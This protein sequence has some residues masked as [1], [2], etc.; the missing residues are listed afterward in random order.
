M[1]WLLVAAR[2]AHFAA[3]LSLLG[4]LVFVLRIARPA[5]A[6]ARGRVPPSLLAP[7]RT[8]AAV[9]W[10]VALLGAI[11]WIALVARD[12]SGQSLWHSVAGDS[13]RLVLLKTQFGHVS[14]L[15]FLLMLAVLPFVAALGR[16]RSSDGVGTMLAAMLVAATAWLGHAGA[17]TG[18]AGAIH[19][20]ADALHLVAAG[21]WVGALLPL[22]LMLSPARRDAISDGAMVARAAATA[23]SD[24]GVACVGTLFVTGLVNA[25]FLTGSLPAL[26]E[27]PYGRLLMLKLLLF[28]VMLGLAAL[29]RLR[30]L[31][32]LAGD[33][34]DSSALA[35]IARHARTEAA[36][37]LAIIAIVG[38][39]GTLPPAAEQRPRASSAATHLQTS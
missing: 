4:I 7:L 14:L 11:A 3:Q 24:L 25:W 20:S 36:L 6:R 21:A 19:L 16:N 34:D 10:L 30:L 28:L 22:A 18:P 8:G 27:T 1:D 17:E 12:L 15:R 29:N 2:I 37:G 32:R 38:I 9:S 35:R 13:F 31:P 33:R 26:T 5:Y 39:L 23:F